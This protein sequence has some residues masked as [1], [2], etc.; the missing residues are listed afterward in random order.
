MN[1]GQ[2]AKALADRFR[3][4]EAEAKKLLTFAL[5]EV[6]GSLKAGRRAYLRGFGAFAK[7]V[8]PGRK[9]RHPRTGEIIWIPPRPDIDF[10]ASPALLRGLGPAARQR[11]QGR[12]KRPA[13]GRAPARR[14]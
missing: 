1:L 3:L 11:A 9:V 10:R 4:P 6:A 2:L 12:S 14:R 5:Q 13:R 7:V 8:R